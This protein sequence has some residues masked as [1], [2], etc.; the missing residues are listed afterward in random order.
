MQLPELLPQVYNLIL[1]EGAFS[2]EGLD[3]SAKKLV[4]DLIRQAAEKKKVVRTPEYIVDH[5]IVDVSAALG[6]G[7]AAIERTLLKDIAAGKNVD[8]HPQYYRWLSDRLLEG[9]T[10]GWSRLDDVDFNAPDHTARSVMEANIFRFSAAKGSAGARELNTIFRAS[11]NFSDFKINAESLLDNYDDNWL[12]TEFNHAVATAQ[13]SSN[14]FGQ[15]QDSDLFPIWEY[16]TVGDDKVRDGHKAIN[17][18]RFR[19]DDPVWN[20]IYPPN[21]FGC[22]CE[23]I[24]HAS[25][26]TPLDNGAEAVAELDAAGDLE[27]MRKGRFDVNRAVAGTVYDENLFYLE[28]FDEREFTPA[29][30]GLP[31]FSK[32]T[33][34]KKRKIVDRDSESANTWYDSQVN[35]NDLDDNNK[36]R[37]VDYNNRPIEMARAIMDEDNFDLVND[38]P[39][40]LNKPDE[41]YLRKITDK[42]IAYEYFK[43]FQGEALSVKVE[44]ENGKPHT[45]LEIA[46]RQ[47]EID[48]ARKGL[49]IFSK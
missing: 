20:T 39:S 6:T 9:F 47:S 48:D 43:F 17:G 41:V 28:G 15:I 23:V 46:R 35:Q 21:G 37:M 3:D 1:Q 4:I 24:K 36:V 14:Y 29:V 13:N 44:V 32:L 7:R 11:K 25:S 22:R 12:R 26:G 8:F 27:Q 40:I 2:P 42:K 19:F 33:R 18:K 16:H 34:L 38:V 49:V 5:A 45:L 10:D 30:N 31:L